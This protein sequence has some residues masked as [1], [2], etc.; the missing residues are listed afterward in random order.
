MSRYT[1]AKYIRL[2]I[3][4]GKTDSLSISSQR[5]ILD[6]HI[7]SLD[8]PGA[9]ILEFVDNGRSGV[10]M[11]RPAVQE[12][13]GLVRSG[14]I[15]AVAV[16]DF[17]R[18][19]RSA[20]D[21]GYFIEQVFPLY[22]VRF[23]SVGD[24]FDS[25][26]YRN[27]TGGID[28]AFKFLMHEYYSQ[29]LS[30]KVKSAKRIQ[31]KRGENIVANAVYG[32]M[33]SG[34]GKWEPDPA[35]AEVVRQIYRLALEGQPTAAIRGWLCASKIPA[36]REY[37]ELK[38]GKDILPACRWESKAICRIL[39]NEQ[40]IGTYIAGKQEQKAVG[41]NSKNT[42]DRPD[43][44]AIPDRH[45]P[46]ISKADFAAAQE[47]RG[48]YRHSRTAKPLGN[49]LE[50]GE[51]SYRRR[52]MVSGER[53]VAA[54]IYGYAKTEGGGLETDE[55]A[56]C[57]VRVIFGL[58]AR[59]EPAK[60]IA[61][62]LAGRGVPK[63]SE[64]KKLAK[65]HNIAPTCGWNGGSVEHVINNEQ[66]TGAYIA[67]RYLT[68]PD[69]GKI[70]RTAKQDWV[71]IPDMYP[72]IVSKQQYDE[73]RAVLAK[74]RY[75]WK[76]MAQRDYLLR[77]NIL[78]CGCCGFA[79][80]YDD[81]LDP[82]YRCQ[83]TAGDRNAECRGLKVPVRGLDETVLA[84]IRKQAEVVLNSDSLSEL[85]KAGAGGKMA[86]DF[87]K[88]IGEC[89]AERQLAYEQFVTREIGRDAYFA[90]KAGCS[91]RIERLSSR[92]A[93][94]KQAERDM[95]SGE[96]TAKLAKQVV[97]GALA[98]R[99]L[100]ETLVEKILVFPGNRVEIQW[101]IADFAAT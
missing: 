12:L 76:N 22:G 19:S 34:S 15:Q 4:D 46:I 51:L 30:I 80:T 11:E 42:V 83:H 101:K 18:F 67:G 43:W 7:E 17:S 100:V 59:G 8:M 82:V 90:L 85:R 47:I 27:D 81:L 69:T 24:S 21:S 50:S 55:A 32:Y 77:G 78:K 97:G 65:G 38:R 20:L 61:S 37:A 39:S 73:V 98:P 36:P 44:I 41:S 63:P 40:Y 28:V 54:A 25:D 26:D 89:V 99:E 66:Y 6:R 93:V 94:L 75:K 49:P 48:R 72:A 64:Y 16:K 68:N 9:E 56:A 96:K 10:S 91:E 87:E 13:L 33:K 23:I 1:I 35:A 14:R 53:P 95:Q 52:R 79:M 71:V 84:I 70:Y 74:S 60:E 31:M 5:M 29:D 62:R 57:V 3:E 88:E 45:T 92:M 58:A 2:S 86:A